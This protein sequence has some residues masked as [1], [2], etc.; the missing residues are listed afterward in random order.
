MFPNTSA[1]CV[2]QFLS[3]SL[4]KY[5]CSESVAKQRVMCGGSKESNMRS[6]SVRPFVQLW[7]KR[8]RWCGLGE[9]AGQAATLAHCRFSPF[10]LATVTVL[11][12]QPHNMH[13]HFNE[14]IFTGCGQSNYCQ[15]SETF[16]ETFSTDK[17][18]PSL[19][20]GKEILIRNTVYASLLVWDS[21]V[22]G[23]N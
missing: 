4:C 7:W 18:K 11:L 13:L 2:C 22:W 9:G 17:L 14:D 20:P 1:Q 3:E 6:L 12:T 5:Y 15:I 10:C 16:S 21:S 23:S 8:M 19:F